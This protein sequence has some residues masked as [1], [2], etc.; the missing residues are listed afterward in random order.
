MSIVRLSKIVD[1][2]SFLGIKEVKNAA[3]RVQYKKDTKIRYD[4]KSGVKVVQKIAF[5][6]LTCILAGYIV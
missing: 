2:I 5:F 6:L 3:E 1:Y 4:T